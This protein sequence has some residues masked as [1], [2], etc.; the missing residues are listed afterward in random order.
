MSFGFPIPVFMD[1]IPKGIMREIEYVLLFVVQAP[2]EVRNH[3]KNP[4]Q[5]AATRP[6]TT[7][8]R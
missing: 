6:K 5:V 7:P 3:R 1:E 4:H 8:G 2:P